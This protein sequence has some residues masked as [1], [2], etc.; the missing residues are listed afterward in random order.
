MTEVVMPEECQSIPITQ[1]SAWN[2]NG[3]LKR[4]SNPE[5]PYESK[6]CSTIADPSCVM[7]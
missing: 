7:R 2:Q 5:G 6:T 3:S 4:V 1:P